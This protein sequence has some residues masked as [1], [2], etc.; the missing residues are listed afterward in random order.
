[1]KN[2]FRILLLSLVLLSALPVFAQQPVNINTATAEELATLP[3]IGEVKAEA[4]VEDRDA[5]GDYASLEE[6]TRVSGIGETTV[7]N[8]SD[9]ATL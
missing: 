8:L 5:N 2:G 7:A 3:G 1:M 9:N 4:I 6:L